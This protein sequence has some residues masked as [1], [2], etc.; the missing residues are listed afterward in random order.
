MFY[1]AW[2][3]YTLAFITPEERQVLQRPS[4][5]DRVGYDN[6][7]GYTLVDLETA[8]NAMDVTTLKRF[9]QSA[10]NDPVALQILGLMR[11][12]DNSSSSVP[13]PK[14]PPRPKAGRA[15]GKLPYGIG[16]GVW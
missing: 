10:C 7:R 13:K 12:K 2:L 4:L 8:I 11:A 9:R 5:A 16:T 3:A 6:G 14:F 1:P 15:K